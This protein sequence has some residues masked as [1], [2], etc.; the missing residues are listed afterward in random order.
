MSAPPPWCRVE[1]HL[2]VMPD[3]TTRGSLRLRLTTRDHPRVPEILWARTR[4]PP[5]ISGDLSPP[6]RRSTSSKALCSNKATLWK[7]V[8]AWE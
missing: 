8:V 4:W 5:A 3:G 2:S 7:W 1:S 6:L